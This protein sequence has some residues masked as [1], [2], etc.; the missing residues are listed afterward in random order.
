MLSAKGTEPGFGPDGLVVSEIGQELDIPGSTLSHHLQK[1]NHENLVDAEELLSFL[2]RLPPP[3]QSNAVHLRRQLWQVSPCGRLRG[4]AHDLANRA[5][6]VDSQ[7]DA[8]V[9]RNARNASYRPT[10][11]VQ[12]QV[13]GRTPLVKRL[14]AHLRSILNPSQTQRFIVLDRGLSR[15]QGLFE[16]SAETERS[17]SERRF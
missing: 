11:R 6:Y 3:V 13:A 2:H 16:P 12:L 9:P 17:V 1:L 5:R 15:W 8:S 4:W 7:C 14:A 10:F